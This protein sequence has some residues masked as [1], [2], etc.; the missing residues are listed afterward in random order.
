MNMPQIPTG[1]WS[2]DYPMC[3]YEAIP[4]IIDDSI[5]IAAGND[6]K[7]GGYST[8]SVVSASLSHL[9]Q[10]SDTTDHPGGQVWK[11]IPDMPYCLYAINHYG[12]YLIT[13]IG[14]CMVELPDEDNAVWKLISL[15]PRYRQL[16]LCRQCHSWIF[17]GYIA[18]S[19][20][21]S[22]NKIFFVG[23]LTGKHYLGN[24]DDLI[25]KI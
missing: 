9:L 16:G 8:C 14:D 21:L 22:P 12:D 1:A 13:F 25:T 11:K 15:Q 24:S 4:L 23:G 17:L 18:R 3:L 7:K 10:G 5:Y 2:N 19:I 6:R 20:H